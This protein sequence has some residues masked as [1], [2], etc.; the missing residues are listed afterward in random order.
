[1]TQ[2]S[3]HPELRHT[4]THLDFLVFIDFLDFSG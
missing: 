3:R 4:H 2:R 1:M